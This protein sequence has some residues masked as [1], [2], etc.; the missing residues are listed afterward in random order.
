MMS[1]PDTLLLYQN[2]NRAAWPISGLHP[3]RYLAPRCEKKTWCYNL[4]PSPYR[5]LLGLS[6]QYGSNWTHRRA[7]GFIAIEES[8]IEPLPRQLSSSIHLKMP[9][10][11]LLS[12]RLQ[13]CSIHRLFSLAAWAVD[14][15]SNLSNAHLQNL[16]GAGV[17]PKYWAADYRTISSVYKFTNCHS[18]PVS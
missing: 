16:I 10:T 1:A 18:S 17:W 4:R 9:N 3:V 13:V 2:E 8:N 15:F 6:G 5:L 7:V 11:A 12:Q 14:K